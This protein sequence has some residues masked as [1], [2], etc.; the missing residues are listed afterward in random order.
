[1][2]Y[3]GVDKSENPVM[4][5]NEVSTNEI[6]IPATS[7]GGQSFQIQPSKSRVKKKKMGS[8]VLV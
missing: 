5:S 8:C 2:L 4:P 6:P 3:I 7:D 1:M